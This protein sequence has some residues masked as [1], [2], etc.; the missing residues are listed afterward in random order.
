MSYSQ[1]IEGM[2]EVQK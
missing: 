1:Q 2:C